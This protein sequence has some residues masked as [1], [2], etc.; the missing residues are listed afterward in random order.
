MERLDDM[1]NHPHKL[2]IR[3]GWNCALRHKVI[4][5]LC[6][7][8]ETEQEHCRGAPG[9][10]FRGEWLSPGKLCHDIREREDEVV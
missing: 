8:V 1:F 10:V 3:G 7:V 2:I 5:G 4:N 6:G 9:E